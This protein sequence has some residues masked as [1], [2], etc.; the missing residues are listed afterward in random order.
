MKK[1]FYIFIIITLQVQL[2]KAQTFTG[3]SV[4][5][6]SNIGVSSA[7]IN[8]TLNSSAAVG[9]EYQF[10]FGTETGVYSPLTAPILTNVNGFLDVNGS[11]T[12]LSPATQYFYVLY[13]ADNASGTPTYTSSEQSFFTLATEP[14]ASVT[15]LSLASKTSSTAA[16]TIDEYAYAPADNGGYVLYAE[17]GSGPRDISTL[18]DGSS[19]DDQAGILGSFYDWEIDQTITSLSLSGLSEASEYTVNVIHYNSDGTVPTLNYRLINPPQLTFW[20]LSDP[21]AGKADGGSF[22]VS[23]ITTNS[24]DINWNDVTNAD[25]YL[26]LYTQNSADLDI[27]DVIDGN[28]PADLTFPAGVSYTTSATSNVSLSSLNAN[29]NYSFYIIPYAEGADPSTINYITQTGPDLDSFTTLCAPPAAQSTFNTIDPADINPLNITVSWNT[30]SGADRYLVVVKE[31]AA[32]S[33]EPVIGDSYSADANFSGGSDL[34][35]GSGT[36]K[37]VYNGIGNSITVTGLDLSTTYHFAVFAYNSDGNCYV[38]PASPGTTSASTTG[39]AANGTIFFNSAS[40]SINSVTN[41]NSG[42]RVAIL[43]FNIIDNGTDGIPT[44]LNRL[45]FSIAAD[46]DFELEGIGWDDIIADARLVNITSGG[47]ESAVNILADSIIIEYSGNESDQ[48]GEKGYIADNTTSNFQLQIRLKDNISSVI[49]NKNIVVELYPSKM[50]VQSNSSLFD[51]SSSSISSGTTNNK[52]EVIASEFNFT[53]EPSPTTINATENFTTAPQVEVTDENGNLDLDYVNGYSLGTGGISVQ[54]PP[55]NFNNGVL[56]FPA[57][58]NYQGSGDG[59]LSIEDA[60]NSISIATSNTIT[61]NPK[62]TLSEIGAVYNDGDLVNGAT[63]EILVGF[64]ITALSSAEINDIV[65]GSDQELTGKLSNIRLYASTD[66]TFDGADVN[67]STGSVNDNGVNTE[68]TFASLTESID[69][70]SSYYF[71]VAAVSATVPASTPDITFSLISSN[72]N[73][74]ESS[75]LFPAITIDKTYSFQDL[76]PPEIVSINASPASISDDDTGVEAFQISIE[77]DEEMITDGTADPVITFPTIGE[78]PTTSITFSATSS[79]WDVAGL[80]YTSYYNVVDVGQTIKDIDVNIASAKDIS[81]NSMIA[82]DENDLFSIDTENPIASLS[83][84]QS[85]V[86]LPN[87][88]I[89]LTADFGELMDTGTEPTVTISAPTNFSLESGSWVNSQRYVYSFTHDGTEELINNASITISGALDEAGNS[90]SSTDSDPFNINTIPPKI[91]AIS[92]SNTTGSYKEGDGPIEITIDFDEIVTLG[93]TQSPQLI[94]N[95]SGSAIATYS[96]HTDDLIV[97]SY[98]ITAGD[99]A[100]PLEVLSLDLNGSTIVSSSSLNPAELGLQGNAL[101]DDKQLKIDTQSPFITAIT[102]STVDG[103]YGPGEI[104]NI[105]VIFNENIQQTGVPPTLN[106]NTG[107]SAIFDDITNGNELNFTYTIGGI[108]QGENTNDLAVSSISLSQNEIL[109][110]VGNPSDLTLNGANNTLAA[111]KAIIIDTEPPSLDPNPFSPAN[112]SLNVSQ[113]KTFAITLNEQVTGAGTANI[114]LIDVASGST[115]ATLD[116]S[117]AFSNSS[118]TTLNFNSLAASLQ[119]STEYYFEFDAGAITDLA[120]NPLAAFTGVSNWSFTTFGPARIDDFSIAACVGEVFTISGQYFTGVSQIL[121]DVESGSPFEITTFSIDDDNTISFTVPAGTVPGKITLNKINGQDGNTDDA[122]TTSTTAIKVGPSSGQIVLV[123]V[124]TDVVCDVPGTEAAPIETAIQFDIVGGSGTY[125]VQYSDGVNIFTENNY[126]SGETVQ[127]NP[128]VSGA[129]TYS[130]I[131]IIDE[132]PD[133]N[134]CSAADNGVDLVI[135]EYEQSNVEAGGIFDSDLGVSTVAVCLAQDDQVDLSDGALMGVL[136]SIVGDIT[137][138]EWTIVD[139]P[140]SGGGGFSSNFSEKTTTSLTPTYYPS[141]ADAAY[142]SITLRLTSDDPTAP[143]PCSQDFDEITIVF[144]NTISVNVGPDLNAC[145]QND[146]SGPYVIEPLSATLGGGATSLEWS[147]NDQYG[148]NGVHDGSWGFAASANATT[149]T[150]TS[151]LENPFYKASPQ[152]IANGLATVG[153]IPTS[154]G[155]GGT[156][157]P[158]ELNININDLPAPTIS[159]APANVCSGEFGV[160]F[161]MS[162]SSTSST[163]EWTLS[164]EGSDTPGQNDKNSIDGPRTGNIIFVDFKEVTTETVEIITVKE[165]NPITTCESVVQTINVTIKPAPVANITYTGNTTVS[166]GDPRFLLTGEGG[167]IGNIQSGG[168]FSGPGVVQDSD[169]NYYLDPSILN[170]TDIFDPADD[171]IITFTYTDEFGCPASETIRFNVYAENSSFQNLLAQY[172]VSDEEDIIFVQPSILGDDFEVISIQGPGITELGLQ[173]EIIDGTPTQVFKAVFNPFIAYE[174]NQAAAD[175]SAVVISFSTREKLNPANVILEAGSQTVRANPL[176]TLEYQGPE[177]DMCTYDEPADLEALG[178]NNQNTYS[179]ILKDTLNQASFPDSLIIGDVNV[180]LQFDPAPLDVY[181]DSIGEESIEVWME[182]SYTNLNSCSATETFSFIVYKQPE[183]PLLSSTDLCNING[184][185]EEA[186]VTNYDGTNPIQELEWF[187]NVDLTGEPIGNGLTFTPPSELFA[188]SNEVKFYVVRKNVNSSG[189]DDELCSSNATE[190][191]Y[192][193]L[194]VPT[195][196]WNKSSYG[197]A[198]IIFTA[199]HNE[200]NVASYDW[201]INRITDNGLELVYSEN[202]TNIDLKQLTVDFSQYGA[203]QYQVDFVINTLFNCNTSVSHQIV[204]VPELSSSSNFSF[205]FNSSNNEWVSS[206]DTNNSWEWNQPGDSSSI[207]SESKLWITNA[208]GSYNPGEQSYVYSPV[209]DISQIEKPAVN[210]DLWIDVIDNVDGLILEYSTDNLRIE[211]P[212]KQWSLLGNFD[213]GISSGLNWYESSAIRSRPGTDNITASGLVNNN[214]FGQGWSDETIQDELVKRI[215]AK[216][217]LD[218][219][220]QSERS[221]VM[222]RFQFKSNNTGFLPDGVAF[223]NFAIGSLNRNV[224][225]EYFG[226]EEVNSDATEMDSLNS[227]F[228][229]STSFTWINYRLNESDPLFVQNASAMLSRIYQYDAYEADN[230]FSIDGVLNNE[231][232]FSSDAAQNRLNNSLLVSSAVNLST[233]I[234]KAADDQLNV[235]VNY[236]SNSIFSENAR[237]FVTVLYKEVSGGALETNP[238]KTYYNVLRGI[239]PQVE[240][241]DVSGNE[242]GQLETSFLATSANDAEPLMVVSFIQDIETGE[243]FQSDFVT[244][245]PLLSYS[246]VTSNTA[247]EEMNV[248]LYP[249]PA[250]DFVNLQFNSTLNEELSIRV[251]DMRGSELEA[252]KLPAG[253]TQHELSTQSFKTGMYHI[254]ISNDKGA[255]KR[256]KFSVMD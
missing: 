50:T 192:R 163:F 110:L 191:T 161:R 59:T 14:T 78:D 216:H 188:N 126:L 34:P 137:S 124:G 32:V 103:I 255:F 246:N 139:G 252:I 121:T 84:N 244:D 155:C 87:N 29:S 150:L 23:N 247:L 7:T 253:T 115:L 164:N 15:G 107:V 69:N 48:A 51:A 86:N 159:L 204:V 194:G 254:I 133:L 116:G 81:N 19:P 119:D 132:D 47:N 42:A 166:Q 239:L 156:P 66:D 100:D 56:D 157:P 108:S 33:F 160:R 214:V 105:K 38:T 52:V 221:N 141:L 236:N 83:L 149:F 230:A 96:S 167:Q 136:P 185:I 211:D 122:S 153:A 54:N 220:S 198:P 106:L 46:D 186:S 25:K 3:V 189:E 98:T 251:Y 40:V 70:N 57:N 178:S 22:S 79:G 226:N 135:T 101:S 179:F 242:S 228:A 207:I 213:D 82:V 187:T 131:S 210:F 162:P 233:E 180:G 35:N 145:I 193:L 63:D 215:Q 200:N 144:V 234:S 165:I 55:A 182:Y 26:I 71:I 223:D 184:N 95:S 112:G 128:P 53:Q 117:T 30:V 197:S 28:A 212:N 130:I 17:P 250:R 202:Q 2:I 205:D 5:P 118:A 65:L 18:Q 49:D 229:R 109:D 140:S 171:H 6:A 199:N 175:P 249:N 74:Q 248:N 62:I 43:D 77:F 89:E 113:T 129:N 123:S 154:G 76:T 217:A 37:A 142:G 240:G 152:E 12:G 85:L 225:V 237:L 4:S 148:E 181:L 238:A 173:T 222:F 120:G 138:G 102:S 75:Y 203:G 21:P 88:T 41:D 172:C 134:T 125:T 243:V 68:I 190:I 11:V 16:F 227:R 146:G 39:A 73:F 20:T 72:F 218:V 93:G 13:G 64:D 196:E 45:A 9:V 111:N 8:G 114:R 24:A 169:G 127:V 94:L 91:E 61:V 99:N 219:L 147:R 177:Y 80:V 170:V 206:I 195:L 232:S 209:M 67:I 168:V 90:M 143:N 231:F 44:E 104:V 1:Y 58:F 31:G 60:G 174:D 241:V 10:R 176:P 201:F 92:S 208:N 256:L 97:F 235:K 151:T 183:Q 27:N 224:L 36:N 158:E 245:V